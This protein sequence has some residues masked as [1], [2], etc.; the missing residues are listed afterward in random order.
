M[1]PGLIRSRR[2]TWCS[3]WSASTEGAAAVLPGYAAGENVPELRELIQGV[4]AHERADAGHTGSSFILNRSPL[5]SFFLQ[6]NQTASASHT[7]ERN[8]YMMKR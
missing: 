8:L 2:A 7:M 1:I 3:Y 5:P 4:A 6:L